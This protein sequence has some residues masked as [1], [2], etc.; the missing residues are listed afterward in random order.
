MT[1]L[2]NSFQTA[3]TQHRHRGLDERDF[4]RYLGVYKGILETPGGQHWLTTVGEQFFDEE[5]LELLA[6]AQGRKVDSRLY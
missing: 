2:M 5:A 3:M 4:E 1:R 6:G